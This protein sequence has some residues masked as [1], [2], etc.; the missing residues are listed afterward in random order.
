MR[1]AGTIDRAV[2]VVAG[3]ALGA[4][5]WTTLGVAEGTVLGI[6]AVAVGAVLVITGLVGFCPAY[7]L[8]G[9]RT[10]STK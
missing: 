8:L 9:V 5:A 3:L 4:L 6:A 1:N 7:R 2:R 10:C